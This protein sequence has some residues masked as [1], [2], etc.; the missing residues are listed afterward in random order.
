V[1]LLEAIAQQVGLGAER[2][3]LVEVHAAMAGASAGTRLSRLGALV[4]RL[5][6]GVRLM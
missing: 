6:R 1:A 3:T 5:E 2:S 4:D